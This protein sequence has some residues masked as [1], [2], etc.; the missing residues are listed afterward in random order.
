M[1]DVT[2][3]EFLKNPE[4]YYVED[5]EDTT[6]S[7]AGP[8][9]RLAVIPDA[10]RAKPS[11]FAS[12]PHFGDNLFDSVTEA[13]AAWKAFLTEPAPHGNAGWQRSWQDGFYASE[14]VGVLDR[15]GSIV[16]DLGANQRKV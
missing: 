6:V 1:E 13:L 10:G 9:Y 3:A 12:R 5:V 14:R 4:A 2:L 11:V 8:P 15:H 7:G 16:R